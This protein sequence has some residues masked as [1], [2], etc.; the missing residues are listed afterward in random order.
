MADIIDENL[1]D[2]AYGTVLLLIGLIIAKF[3][4]YLFRILVARSSVS[5]YGLFS[6]GITILSLSTIFVLIGL[7]SGI[8]K[9][10][11]FYKGKKDDDMVRS[12]IK[13]SLKIT[14]IS[15]IIFGIILFLLSD[16]LSLYV[17]KKPGLAIILKIFA[18]LLPFFTISQ[19]LFNTLVAYRRIKYILFLTIFEYFLVIVLFLLLIMLNIKSLGATLAYTITFILISLFSVF[20]VKTS[21]FNKLT[22]KKK[23]PNITKI[24]LKFSSQVMFNNVVQYFIISL[25][26]ILI[27]YFL[28]STEVGIYSAAYITSNILLLLPGV[29]L[30]I[31]VPT[32]SEMFAK[33]MNKEAKEIFNQ[34]SRWIFLIG[35][36][37]VSFVSFFSKSILI[38]LFGSNYASGDITFI[39]LAIAI[40][41]YSM[42]FAEAKTLEISNYQRSLFYYLLT[43]LTI[44]LFMNIM[45]I[46]RYGIIGS[47]ISALI[48]FFVYS[49]LCIYKCRKEIKFTQQF[50]KYIIPT[51][52]S[53]LSALSIYFIV[54][55]IKISTGL[56]MVAFFALLHVVICILLWWLLKSIN[57]QDIQLFKNIFSR[58]SKRSKATFETKKP[59][60]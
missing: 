10:V 28:S 50:Q 58:M 47:A 52:T 33:N 20:A 13:T 40:L 19:I 35:I 14:L 11:S 53:L 56:I 8:I 4:S 27:G 57:N 32:I 7:D 22:K 37:F 41:F 21:I 43:S 48:T 30:W 54:N 34:V 60:Q 9:F 31:F 39:L 26:T 38:A 3:F 45:L 2:F 24:L 17:F 12:F 49:S 51:I 23:N 5:E 1:N 15:S 44:N 29:F 36:I 16:I 59:K 46:P 6:L 55:I 25:D 42:S 18:I